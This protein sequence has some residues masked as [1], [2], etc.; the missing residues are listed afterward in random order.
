VLYFILLHAF[1]FSRSIRLRR[2]LLFILPSISHVAFVPYYYAERVT[3]LS[4]G[5]NLCR[6]SRVG[7]LV[8]ALAV[9]PQNRRTA[10]PAKSKG[11]RRRKRRAKARLAAAAAACRGKVGGTAKWRSRTGGSSSRRRLRSLDSRSKACN[12]TNRTPTELRGERAGEFPRLASCWG[13]KY[14]RK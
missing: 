11:R 3:G 9:C 2:H 13:A 14:G 6:L 7:S 8:P 4:K 5:T 1:C 12:R 10:P